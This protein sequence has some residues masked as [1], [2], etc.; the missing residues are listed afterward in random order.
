MKS[1]IAVILATQALSLAAREIPTNQW[2]C[3]EKQN[4]AFFISERIHDYNGNPL[5]T[6][7][8]PNIYKGQYIT[9]RCDKTIPIILIETK[10]QW[11]QRQEANLI[12]QRET[13]ANLQQQRRRNLDQMLK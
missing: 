1:I 2:D 3:L 4:S 12:S 6:Y 8:K 7:D 9:F 13:L 11:T 5:P 10:E